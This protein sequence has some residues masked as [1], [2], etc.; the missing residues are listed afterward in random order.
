MKSLTALAVLASHCTYP[1]MPDAPEA[2]IRPLGASA[3]DLALAA[4]LV[5]VCRAPRI[6]S[7]ISSSQSSINEY[8]GT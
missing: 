7:I 5:F 3:G 6:V 8:S 1:I 4:D 2:T